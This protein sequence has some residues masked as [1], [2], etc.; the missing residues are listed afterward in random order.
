M[1]IGI[2]NYPAPLLI[3]M[4]IVTCILAVFLFAVRRI[5][6]S[7]LGRLADVLQVSTIVSS[8]LIL[9]IYLIFRP[10]INDQIRDIV[11]PR[12][13]PEVT[14]LPTATPTPN[15]PPK[16]PVPSY[17][18]TEV[19]QPPTGTPTPTSI[20]PTPTATASPTSTPD[21]QAII[22]IPQLCDS[23]SPC[24]CT[25]SFQP[26]TQNTS[27][28]LSDDIQLTNAGSADL[29]L[30]SQSTTC[31]DC[32]SFQMSSA[33][34]NAVAP[35]GSTTFQLRYYWDRDPN[36]GQIHDHRITLI[37]NS[38]NCPALAISVPIQYAMAA[39]TPQPTATTIVLTPR[40]VSNVKVQPV[41]TRQID[42]QAGGLIVGTA[43]KFQE[44][45]AL[46]QP[47]CTAFLIRGPI[48]L[49]L[50]VWYGGWD[51]WE[52]IFDDEAPEFLLQEKVQELQRHQTCPARG[53]KVVRIP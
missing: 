11:L 23:I 19:V 49:Q 32:L 13:A 46:D 48:Q 43:D 27:T 52:N 26:V 40:E 20:P 4:V 25:W 6:D 14:I 10:Q 53:I 33:N 15:Q 51:Q 50:T 47:E 2:Q 44:D 7:T 8:L 24:D 22:S 41:G 9:V 39:P 31:A 36:M 34:G 17:T 30:L 37:T 3:L 16:F 18:P 29:I 45:V 28:P 42:L 1:D 12:P 35:G 5:K 38:V 21:L